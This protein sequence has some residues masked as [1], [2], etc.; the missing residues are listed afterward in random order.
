MQL[1]AG[2]RPPVRVAHMLGEGEEQM[3]RSLAL[4]IFALLLL[5][6]CATTQSVQQARGTGEK[7][8]FSAHYEA[9][10]QATLSAAGKQGLTLT[11]ADKDSGQILLSHGMTPWSWGKRV[12]IFVT[13]ISNSQTQVE[14]VSK[15]DRAPLNFP[16]DW[17]TNLL[18]AI[19]AELKPQG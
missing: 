16:A 5:G 11:S 8:T 10:Y 18:Q 6:A 13:K 4:A 9:V 1:F 15:P 14:I 3:R 19:G 17:V 12:A 2:V 7:R